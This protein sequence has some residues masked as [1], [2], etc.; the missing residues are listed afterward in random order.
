MRVFRDDRSAVGKSP[1]MKQMQTRVLLIGEN[2]Q[3]SSFLIKRLEERGCKCTLATSYQDAI[4]RLSSQDFDLVLSPMR[5][6]ERSVF[7]LIGLLERSRTTLFYFQAVEE[8]CWWLPALRFGRNCFGSNA[9]RPSEFMASLDVVIDEIQKARSAAAKSTAS[10]MQSS[11]AA[12][13]WPNR[14][15]ATIEPCVPSVQTY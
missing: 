14:R 8:G 2:S 1:N 15:P 9:L 5:A 12:L 4:T 11:P 6:R 7:P 3:G 13:P 10:T